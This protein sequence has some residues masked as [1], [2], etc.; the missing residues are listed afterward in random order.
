[1]FTVLST[2]DFHINEDTGLFDEP[3]FITWDSS[4]YNMRKF[5]TNKY[6]DFSYWYIYTPMK[7]ANRLS[8]MNLKLNTTCLNYD[9]ISLAETNFSLSN[10]SVGFIDTLSAFFNKGNI[11]NWE[12]GQKLTKLKK[13]QGGYCFGRIF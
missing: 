3:F 13:K 5:F 9:I 6:K 11:T 4:F 12:L 10:E 2:S 7:F 8:V 1:M